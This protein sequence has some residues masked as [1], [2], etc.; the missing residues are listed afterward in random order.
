MNLIVS[1]PNQD[2]KVVIKCFTYNHEKY[3]EDALKG[4]IMQKTNFPFCAIV[5]DDFSIDRTAEII[6]K[7]EE[8]YP[9]IIK[10]IYL[11]ENYRSQNKAKKPFIQPWFDRSTYIAI[12]EGDDYWIDEYKLQ[13]QVDWLD[14]HPDY[15]MCCTDAKVVSPNGELDWHRYDKDSDITPEEMILGGGFFIQTPTLLY[16]KAIQDYLKEKFIRKCSTGDYSLQIMCS[17]KGKVRYLCVKSSV[18]RFQN[19]GSWSSKDKNNDINNSIIYW[20]SV[21]QM[22]DGFDVYT[23]G[24]YSEAIKQRKINFITEK[25]IKYYNHSSLLNKEFKDILSLL[26]IKQNIVLFFKKKYY[27]LRKQFK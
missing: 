11:Q 26:T 2:Y 23:N 13:K 10:G 16:R 6:R 5:V 8:Q 15:S 25:I 12:C 4:F 18:Y 3:I 20:R 24:K 19:P 21:L 7:Y 17:I 1:E 14:S 27:K 9:D 22:L